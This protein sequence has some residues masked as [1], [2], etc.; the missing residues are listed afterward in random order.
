MSLD[1]DYLTPTEGREYCVRLM[2]HAMDPACQV[3]TIQR[4]VGSIMQDNCTSPKSSRL[5]TD[6]LDEHSSDIS[7]I[8]WP[9]R[10]TVVNP[11]KHPWNALEHG[12]K[13]HHT[14]T[15]NLTKL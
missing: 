3:G 11:I 13:G 5:A 9:P 15:P 14:A 6:W 2:I 7:V 1:S 8:N 12:V 10:S 4:H